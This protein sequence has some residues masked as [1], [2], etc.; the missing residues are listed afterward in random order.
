MKQQKE[1]IESI[2]KRA[3][4]GATHYAYP[5]E[6]GLN[7]VFFKIDK[8]MIVE[9]AWVS[10]LEPIWGFVKDCGYYR[11]DYEEGDMQPYVN[12]E[13]LVELGSNTHNKWIPDTGEIVL[14]KRTDS[15]DYAYDSP[16]KME[17]VAI[18][19]DKV[20]LKNALR[21]LV[22]NLDNIS[23]LEKE[24]SLREKLVEI[25]SSSDEKKCVD[26]Y[27]A[28]DRLIRAGIRLEDRR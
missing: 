22:T 13:S 5:V 24:K 21:D 4:K 1:S 6:Q 19:G 27:C 11:A 8:D 12:W 7:E 9:T 17:V 28:A 16:E 3:P 25:M 23:P 20:W 26:V 2:V 15:I 18:V 14:F 10:S